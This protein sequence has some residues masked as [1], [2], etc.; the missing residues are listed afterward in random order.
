[1]LPFASLLDVLHAIAVSGLEDR[2]RSTRSERRVSGFSRSE[3]RANR[4]RES[5]KQRLRDLITAMMLAAHHTALGDEL[6]C[7]HRWAA[8]AAQHRAAM[9]ATLDTQRH[10]VALWSI[11]VTLTSEPDYI[12]ILTRVHVV[13]AARDG[14]M[15]LVAR[16]QWAAVRHLVDALA[17]A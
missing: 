4:M 15:P 6:Q 8:G 10:G 17:A 14:V 1:M 9:R 2:V 13:L 16:R 12:V 5:L 11:A 3:R 7:G